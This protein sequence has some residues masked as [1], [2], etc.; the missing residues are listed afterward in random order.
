MRVRYL[1]SYVFILPYRRRAFIVKIRRL[2]SV[3][4]RN[5]C[6]STYCTFEFGILFTVD[7][8]EFHPSYRNENTRT[9]VI[10]CT[11]RRLDFSLPRTISISATIFP[12]HF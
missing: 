12:S 10:I 2:T 7:V 3:R 1:R 11:F 9:S 6:A 8:L 5:V 4:T